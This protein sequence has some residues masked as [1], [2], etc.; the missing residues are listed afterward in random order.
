MPL[1]SRRR[2]F[3]NG[4]RIAKKSRRKFLK[5]VTGGVTVVATGTFAFLMSTKPVLAAT[6]VADS[7]SID[8]ASGDISDVTISP[9]VTLDWGNL[10]TTPTTADM[11]FAVESSDAGANQLETLL[12]R[13]D[14]AIPTDQ[15]N[16][17]GKATFSTADGQ[18]AQTS[19][20][21]HSGI[22]S[23]DFADG[24][25]GDGAKVTTVGVEL[26]SQLNDSAGSQIVSN[27]LT[28]DF[29]VSVTNLASGMTTSGTAGTGV[30]L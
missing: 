13:T 23:A 1:K 21:S 14:L 24:T 15:Q 6:F 3:V 26:S 16:P 29:A 18:F 8:S 4:Q 10:N 30:E 19:I 17:T 7:V 28:T 12:Q 20:L 2:R 25:E 9:S 27:T 22:E 11:S 5:Y